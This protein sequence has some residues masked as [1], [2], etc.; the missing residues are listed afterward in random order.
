MY[1]FAYGSNLNLEHMRRICGWHCSLLCR[2]SLPDY[3]IGLDSRGYANIRPKKGETIYGLLY[4]ID[5]DGIHMLDKF[6]GYPKV[7]DRQ[8]VM[9]FDENNVK[10]KAQVY[11]EPPGEF[12]GT[13]AKAEYFRRV[14]A[15]AYEH[16]LPQEWI[17]KLEGFI[18]CGNRHGKNSS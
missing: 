3:E 13:E 12:G 11:I 16:K 17:R 4:E 14:V 5:E 1:Y 6:E 15:A 2:T 7:F 10:Y 8:E 18:E 9:V